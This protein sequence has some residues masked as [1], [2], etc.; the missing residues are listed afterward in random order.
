MSDNLTNYFI[1]VVANI[2]TT[3]FTAFCVWI[4]YKIKEHIN[5]ATIKEIQDLKQ[6]VSSK[7]IVID[8]LKLRLSKLELE[9]DNRTGD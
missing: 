9:R 4:W 1:G 7:D 3:M 8:D 5:K 2:S 6:M